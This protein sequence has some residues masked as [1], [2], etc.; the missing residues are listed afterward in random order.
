[1]LERGPLI[2][3]PLPKPLIQVPPVGG[4]FVALGADKYDESAAL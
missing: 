4:D 1:M 2:E 3:I